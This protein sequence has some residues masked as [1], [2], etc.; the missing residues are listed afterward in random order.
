LKTFLF[1]FISKSDEDNTRGMYIWTQVTYGGVVRGDTRAKNHVTCDFEACVCLVG[2]PWL[3]FLLVFRC[4]FM[5]SRQ[6]FIE[7]AQ[8]TTISTKSIST[9]SSCSSHP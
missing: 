2:A 5:I 3:I 7:A 4:R 8:N 1:E 9:G 6:R